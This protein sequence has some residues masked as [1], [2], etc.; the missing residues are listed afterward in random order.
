[1]MKRYSRKEFLIA[2]FGDYFERQNGFVIVKSTKHLDRRVST[3]YFPNVEILA[4]EHYLVDQD[5]YFGVCPRETMKPDRTHIRFVTAL[6]AGLDL[7]SEGYSGKNVFFSGPASAAKAVRSFPLPPSIIVES[8]WGMHLYWLLRDV[9]EISDRD[10]V[11]ELLR[12]ISDYFQCTNHAGIDAMLRL[13]GTFNCKMVGKS[14]PC[15]IKYM[16]TDFSYGLEDFEQMHLGP[17]IVSKPKTQARDAEPIPPQDIV[18]QTTTRASSAAVEHARVRDDLKEYLFTEPDDEN[19]MA[20]D[21]QALFY[22]SPQKS[23]DSDTPLLSD[24]SAE[25][26]ADQIVDKVVE[27]LSKRLINELADEIV[28]KLAKKLTSG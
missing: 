3:R 27:N 17:D 25:R 7:G 22:E 10:R 15:D 2:L 12:K 14:V 8:G 16:N 28:A 11:E 4:K 24:A 23:H 20:T 26:I 18:A 9:V 21:I 19:E 1:M 5:V 6:W 13:P